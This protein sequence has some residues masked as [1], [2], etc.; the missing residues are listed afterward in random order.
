MGTVERMVSQLRVNYD[1]EA[2]HGTP[3]RRILDGIDE[4]KANARPI[5]D[6]RTIAELLAHL[7]AWIEIVERRLTGERF[8]ITP[9][10]DFPGVEGVRWADALKRLDRAHGKLLKTTERLGDSDLTAP[11]AGH[12]YSVDFMLQGLQHHN[13][14]HGAQIAL[15]KK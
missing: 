11:V 5:P 13:T 8:E 7:T 2:W 4:A 12:Q 9:E 1:G 14:Y 6:A 15:L 3:L 10:M